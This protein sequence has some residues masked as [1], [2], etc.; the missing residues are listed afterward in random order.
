MLA[1][2]VTSSLPDVEHVVVTLLPGGAVEARIRDAGVAIHTVRAAGGGAVRAAFDLPRRLRTLEPDVV[3]GWLLQG[4]L[5]ATY[6]ATVAGLR[7]PVLWNVRWTLYDMASERWRTR[8]LLRLSGA[9]SRSPA[10]ILYNSRTAVGQHAALGYPARSALVIP[11]GFDTDRLRPD[12]DAAHEVRAELGIGPSS[13]II[14]MFA[15]FH[16]MK[17]HG[18]S[19][20]AAAHL[21]QQGIP[22]CFVY[23]GRGV[24][25]ENAELR[26]TIASL[27][28]SS[29]VRLLGERQ[30]LRR[31]FAACDVYWMSSWARGIAEGFPNVVG[32]AMSCG[33]PCVVTDVGDASW[34]VGDTGR[35]VPPRDPVALASAA[36]ELIAGGPGLLRALGAAARARMQAEF[37]LDR[38]TGAYLR[39]YRELAAPA[40]RS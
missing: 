34:I 29:H 27:G 20:R 15:R 4:N 16:P 8:T 17:D 21:V 25:H 40:I 33:V 6:A 2:L 12:A 13:L 19:L 26:E 24:V 32:E 1:R 38:V 35:V 31:L 36:A 23:A 7:A 3:Q 10:R 30:D 9:L 37:S 14:G 22:A 18:N 39:L 5:A 28:L 11:N